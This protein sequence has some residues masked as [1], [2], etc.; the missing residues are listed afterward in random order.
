MNALLLK[1]GLSMDYSTREWVTQR[2]VSYNTYCKEEFVSFVEASTDLMVT[3]SQIPRRH[4]YTSLLLSGNRKGLLNCFY[5]KTGSVVTR[6]IF[7][8]I[9]IPDRIVKQMIAWGMK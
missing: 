4:D 8:I 7:D 1:L 3:N 9:P 6:W 5:F 2:S